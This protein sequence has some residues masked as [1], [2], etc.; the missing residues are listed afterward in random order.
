LSGSGP[1]GWEVVEEALWAKAEEA[2]R[3][4]RGLRKPEVNDI[5]ERPLYLGPPDFYVVNYHRHTPIGAFNPGAALDGDR[6][7]IFVRLVFEFYGYISSVGLAEVPVEEALSGELSEKPL[8]TRIILWPRE[9]WEHRG[10]EDPRAFR[11][12]DGK[13]LILYCAHGYYWLAGR[14]VQT[15]AL[16]LAELDENFEVL[17]RGYF[18]VRKGE[19]VWAP[20]NRD[21]AILSLRGREATLATRPVVRGKKLCWRAL[22]DLEGLEMPEEE[23]RPVMAPEEWE[24]H[25]GWSTNAVRLSKDEYLIGWHGVANSDLAYRNGLAILD[26]EGELLAVSDYVLS[27]RS[28]YEEYGDRCMTL[29]G[30]GLVRYKELLI[31]VGG[32]CDACVGIFTVE[33]D[34]ALETLR[35]MRG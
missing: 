35:W 33:L 1:A 20:S 6:L 32:V 15:D 4:L 3:A 19:H 7:L 21:S 26:G 30:N 8:R 27:P 18:S 9:P 31:W 12:P 34:R 28:L 23:L 10:C 2:L 14:R 16:A 25:I 29:F 22:A 11:T 5:F 17:R 13:W 24:S